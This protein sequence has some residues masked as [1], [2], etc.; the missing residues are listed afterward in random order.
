MGAVR[1]LRRGTANMDV[2]VALATTAAYLYSLLS[3]LAKAFVP[4]YRGQDFLQTSAMLIMF[5][6][7]GKY[8]EVP[9]RLNSVLSWCSASLTSND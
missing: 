6:L 5:I 7:L 1:S 9:L 8:L 3:L 4:S 2:L